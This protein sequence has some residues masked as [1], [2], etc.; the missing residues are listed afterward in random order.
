MS[1]ATYGS[2]DRPAYTPKKLYRH[3]L[4]L[5]A[6]EILNALAGMEGGE[7]ESRVT[8]KVTE[9]GGNVGVKFALF[10]ADVSVG[11]KGGKKLRDELKLKRT[12]HSAAGSLIKQLTEGNGIVEIRTPGDLD[13]VYETLV[14]KFDAELVPLRPGPP[15]LPGRWDWLRRADAADLAAERRAQELG[16][17]HL[18]AYAELMAAQRTG[19]QIAL[20]LETAYLTPEYRGE[21]CRRATVLGQL[22]YVTNPDEH[23]LV[24][25]GDADDGERLVVEAIGADPGQSD[26]MQS[27]QPVRNALGPGASDSASSA[28]FLKRL[29]GRHERAAKTSASLPGGAVPADRYL[30]AGP[31]E[32]AE[33][34]SST[35][36]AASTGSPTVRVDDGG[37]LTEPLD[38]TSAGGGRAAGLAVRGE[39]DLV[40]LRV[41][42]KPL[43][44]YK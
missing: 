37:A 25:R 21:F 36:D 16:G 38:G 20:E 24:R 7:E 8:T 6:G 44:I 14:V 1:S 43:C 3:Y 29:F 32:A 39:A 10:G 11:G 28:G 34:Q 12:I 31:V 33:S 22:I 26:P 35:G 9:L 2:T 41:A 23:L 18:V 13:R 27:D 5:D 17:W 42:V 19:R 4:Y 30:A 40:G 15:R